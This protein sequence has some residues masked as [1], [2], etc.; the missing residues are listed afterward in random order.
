[1]S[2][3]R[4]LGSTISMTVFA[5]VMTALLT[6]L[7]FWQLERRD[8]KHALIAALNARLAAEPVKLPPSS[9]WPHLN[10]SDDEFRRVRFTATFENKPDAMI[11][12][13]SSAVRTDIKTP[14]AWAFLPARLESGEQVVVNAGFVPNEMQGRAEEDRAVAPLLTGKPE[15]LTGYLRFPEHPGFLTAHENEP[16]RLWFIR[17]VPGIAA[18]LNWGKVA[19]FYIDLETPV[20]AGA[21]PK[22]GAL[23]PKLRD[24]HL[25]YAITWFGLALAVFGTFGFWL[26]GRR[27]A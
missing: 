8:E 22:P 3:A 24:N 2:Q 11:Y 13:S 18:S 15:T 7:G 17:D 9:D 4:S 25:Q 10:R 26:F 23:V 21:V 14:G 6:G 1:M 16:K 27:R 19:P 12:T 5:L 20:P